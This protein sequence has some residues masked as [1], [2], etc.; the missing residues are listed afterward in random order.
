M[1]YTLFGQERFGIHQ[2]GP[3][4]LLRQPGLLSIQLSQFAEQGRTCTQTD[5]A[6]QIGLISRTVATG[7]DM[8]H[9]YFSS[10]PI[11]D[12]GGVFAHTGR[13][14]GAINNCD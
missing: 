7:Q 1:G 10:R 14:G 5:T 9:I 13:I 8:Y 6:T 3:P 4:A 12:P 11:G 2:N